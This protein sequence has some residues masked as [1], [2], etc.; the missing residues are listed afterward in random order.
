MVLI[1]LKCML[2]VTEQSCKLAS[3]CYSIWLRLSDFLL[4]F[5]KKMF[6]AYTL[7]ARCLTKTNAKNAINLTISTQPW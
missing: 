7:L 6:I 1:N 5:F 4:N 2:E 3:T